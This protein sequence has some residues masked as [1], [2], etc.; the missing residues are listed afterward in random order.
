VKKS[1]SRSALFLGEIVLALLIF[2][3]SSAVCVG[4]LFRAYHISEASSE[5]NQSIFYAQNAAEVFKAQPDIEKVAAI[6][7]GEIQ[8]GKCYVYYDKN[9]VQTKEQRTVFTLLISP[10]AEAYTTYAKINISKGAAAVFELV[11]A[12]YQEDGVL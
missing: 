4:L 5:L 6:L 12:V 7:G 11:A 1:N 10:S 2:S 8:S 3:L 9:W